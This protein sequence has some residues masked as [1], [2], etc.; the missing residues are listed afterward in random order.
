MLAATQIEIISTVLFFSAIIHTFLVTKIEMVAHR[1]NK[2]SIQFKIIHPLSDVELVFAFWAIIFF[3]LFVF[4][5]GV[6]STLSFATNLNFTEPLF[7]FVILCMAAT[8]GVI[9]LAENVIHG[10]SSL[11]PFPTRMSFYVTSL[12]IGPLLGSLITEPAAMAMTALILLDVLYKEPISPR[13]KYATLALL[14]VNVS[15]G[16]TLT[17]FAAPPVLMVSGKWHWNTLFMLTHFGY[18]AVIAIVASTSLYVWLFRKELR[19]ELTVHKKNGRYFLIHFLFLAGIVLTSHQPKIFLG[20]FVL[21]LG[22]M[23]ITKEHQDPLKIKESV[24]VGLFLAG[25]VVL[26]ALQS[27]WLGPLLSSMNH[28]V[29]FLGATALT[30]ITDNAA[31]TYLGSLVDLSESSKYVLV[32]GAVSG[33]GL[34]VI[35]NAPN[36][37]AYGILKENFGEK[38]INP[39]TLFLWAL[40]PTLIAM[41]SFWV[42]P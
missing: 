4:T 6:S 30:G 27:W 24:M 41:I 18:K 19:S 25:L 22:F 9:T 8:R 20:I 11:L 1:F 37:I 26:G 35:A 10:I 42:L 15:I 29:L 13:L 2:E 34:T 36:P 38:G 16:G 31:L 39:I 17:H 3:I 40:T 14:L 21:F 12:I 7:V 33:G 5:Q 23:K 32:A 28:F